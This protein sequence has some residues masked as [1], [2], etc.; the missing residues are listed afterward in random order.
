M[1]GQAVGV[2][3]AGAAGIAA[4]ALR[5]VAEAV[6]CGRA[7]IARV[8]RAHGG[9]VGAAAGGLFAGVM[10]IGCIGTNVTGASAKAGMVAF[11]VHGP[12][13]AVTGTETGCAVADG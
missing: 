1:A 8:G 2:V 11:A 7:E 13:A 6:Q 12:L 10:T 4:A 3:G 9:A 5:L